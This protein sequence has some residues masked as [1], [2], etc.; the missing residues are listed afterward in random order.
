MSL[1]KQKILITGGSGLIGTAVRKQL[2]LS[3]L[4]DTY[5]PT[6]TELDMTDELLVDKVFSNFQPNIVINL[7]AKV[8]GILANA[9]EPV[10]FFHDNLLIGLYTY[11]YSQKYG[12]QNIINAGAGCG[13]PLDAIEPLK[14]SDLWNGIP[15][16]ESIAYSTAK[17]LLTIMAEVYEKEYGIVSTTFIPSNVYGPHDNFDLEK[18]H[19]VPALIHKFYIATE[20]P[21]YEI[22]VW[23]NGSAKRDFIYVDDVA[24]AMLNALDEKRSDVINIATGQQHTI[25]ELVEEISL[26]FNYKGD[27]IWTE[28]KPTG[29]NSREMDIRKIKH[30]VKSW[31][32]TPLKRGIFHTVEWFRENYADATT[33]K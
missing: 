26:A 4:Y 24:T 21:A 19:V 2:A 9:K 18:G 3:K 32:P 15:Q 23:G 5:A 27:I 29:T 16:S 25:K 8:G 22:E 28:K 11:K 10:E 31:S 7:A 20:N 13:Y 1:N 12:V 17:K 30:L 33:R 6:K 14:E